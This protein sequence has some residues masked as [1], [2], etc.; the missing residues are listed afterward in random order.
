MM[1]K[2]V[3]PAAKKN[4]ETSGG[5]RD[6]WMGQFIFPN[7]VLEDIS[8]WQLIEYIITWMLHQILMFSNKVKHTEG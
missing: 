8:P 5:L 7:I 3:T 4:F 6:L 1:T 2:R